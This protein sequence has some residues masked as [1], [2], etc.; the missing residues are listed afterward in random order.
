MFLSESCVKISG[1]VCGFY[2]VLKGEEMEKGML[3]S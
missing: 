3:K 1:T 2:G